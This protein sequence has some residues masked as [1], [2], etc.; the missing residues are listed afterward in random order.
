M[1]KDPSYHFFGIAESWLGPG[2]DDS[3]IQIDGYSM[4]RQDRNVNGGG[5]VLYVRN[6]YRITK[7]AS[8][9][10]EG[11]GRPSIPEYLFCEVQQGSSSPILI[12]V[13]YRPPHIAMQKNTDL[14]DKLKELSSDYSHKL[15]M[16]D[17]NA[18]L[19]LAADADAHTIR[20]LAKDLNLKVVQHGPTHRHTPNSYTWIDL[21]LLDDNDEIL[22]YK[23]EC[24]PS[25]G[26]HNIIDV[27]INTFAPAPVRGS[28][29]YRD[30][31]NICPNTLNELLACCDWVGMNSIESDLEGAL[32]NLNSNLNLTIDQ[33]APLKSIN[34][35]KKFAPWLGP[36]LRQ[37]I[38]KRDPQTLQA[39]GACSTAW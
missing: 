30:Y 18:D 35:K 34:I 2:V 24:L 26:K 33:L 37:L 27:T 22:D 36:E 21:I 19:S 38:D 23:N 13:I 10:T 11:L 3:L 17:F 5:V 9:N 12:G 28:F 8:S 20:N 7:L 14:F 32:H 16:G 6:D 25:F 15:I 1:T 29:S 39:Y 31:K 4:I